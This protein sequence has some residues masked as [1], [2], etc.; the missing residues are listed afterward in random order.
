[1][2]FMSAALKVGTR[3][4]ARYDIGSTFQ[5]IKQFLCDGAP[6][7]EIVA[8]SFL[9]C[10]KQFFFCV[11]LGHGFGRLG[12]PFQFTKNTKYFLGDV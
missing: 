2:R 4:D 5:K 7:P 10:A 12:S 11:R 6:Y 3:A 9:C 1:M 8:M